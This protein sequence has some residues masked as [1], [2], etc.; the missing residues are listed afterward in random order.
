[1]KLRTKVT[2]SYVLTLF[3]YGDWTSALLSPAQPFGLHTLLVPLASW[4]LSLLL[5][6]SS[7]FFLS[8]STLA[9]LLRPGSV[10]MLPDGSGCTLSLSLISA[11]NLSLQPYLGA[12]MPSFFSFKIIKDSCG[13]TEDRK[14]DFVWS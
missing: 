14:R 9:L 13:E 3:L 2:P 5:A 6:S 4:L 1:M 7:L 10:W 12:V 8:C 11:A